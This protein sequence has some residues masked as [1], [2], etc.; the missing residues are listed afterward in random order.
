MVNL[1]PF[2]LIQE[3]GFPM[4]RITYGFICFQCLGI[5]PIRLIHSYP[6]IIDTITQRKVYCCLL[7]LGSLWLPFNPFWIQV[8]H[9]WHPSIVQYGKSIYHL[10]SSFHP[11]LHWIWEGTSLKFNFI[12]LMHNFDYYIS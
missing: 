7:V 10:D 11:K 8:L 9:L 4:N 1:L 12:K 2:I 6:L 5:F 3:Y